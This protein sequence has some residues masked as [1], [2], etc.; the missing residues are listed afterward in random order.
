MF[1][2]ALDQVYTGKDNFLLALAR[3]QSTSLRYT[4]NRSKYSGSGKFT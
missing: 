1:K 4:P 3:P 2:K